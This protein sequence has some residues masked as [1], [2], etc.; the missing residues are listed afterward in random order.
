MKD[1]GLPPCLYCGKK[2]RVRNWESLS[3]GSEFYW[4]C[5]TPNCI[6]VEDPEAFE[7]K[8]DCIAEAWKKYDRAVRRLG[9]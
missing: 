5:K 9:K 4:F 7:T 1:K 8:K 3:L 6:V 2:L